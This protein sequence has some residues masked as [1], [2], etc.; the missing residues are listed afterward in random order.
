M[1]LLTGATGF[2]G[3]NLVPCLLTAGYHVRALVRPTSNVDFLQELGV[4]LAYADDITDTLSVAEACVGCDQV[5]HAAGQFRFWGDMP[6]FWRVNVAGTAAVLEAAD[7]AGVKQFVHVSTIAAVG[8]TPGTAVITEE[9]TCRPLDAYQRTKFEGERLALAYHRERGLPVVVLR[10]GAFYGPWGRYAFNR[11]FFEEPL[12][13][14]RIKVNN[15]R[16]VSFPVFVPDVVQ[17]VMLALRKG[18]AGEIY[19]ICSQSLDHN[20]I[21]ATISDLA[22][23]S[24]WRLNIPVAAVL[25]LAKAWTALSRY[26]KK[27]PFYP[28]NLA[29]YVFQD[30]HVSTAKAEQEL[31]FKPTPFVEGAKIT[32]DWYRQQGF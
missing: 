8:E 29:H 5:I 6:S 19:N 17:G 7:Q 32:L 23:I 21:N 22:Q 28:T 1:I 11:L 4:E 27:E 25:F 31:G 30:W 10:P 3:H 24:H 2:L 14:W 16:H 18:Q 26:T 12:R 9:T 20:N 15:G 13:G